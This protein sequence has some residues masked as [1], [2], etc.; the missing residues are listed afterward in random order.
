MPITGAHE[1]FLSTL[2]SFRTVPLQQISMVSNRL[3]NMSIFFFKYLIRNLKIAQKTMF[4][5][6]VDIN[7]D[8]VGLYLFM[9]FFILNFGTG[10]F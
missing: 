8:F 1:G 7:Y 2:Q 9:I 3:R 5:K 4:L 6:N 10:F